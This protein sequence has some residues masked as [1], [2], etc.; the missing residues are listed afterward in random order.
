MLKGETALPSAVV[1]H[2]SRAGYLESV[3]DKE[4]TLLVC[5]RQS[6]TNEA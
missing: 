5:V 4:E 6:A 3:S 2:D 1:A